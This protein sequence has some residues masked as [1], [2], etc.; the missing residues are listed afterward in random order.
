ME[1]KINLEKT[2]QNGAQHSVTQQATIFTQRV[3]NSSSNSSTSDLHFTCI[4]VLFA[5]CK[6][7]Q[8][9]AQKAEALPKP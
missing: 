6:G 5:C 9:V 8:V 7:A 1:Q 4:L 3:T 2:A